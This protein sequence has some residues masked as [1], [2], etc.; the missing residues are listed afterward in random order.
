MS[1]PALFELPEGAQL[2]PVEP[3]S[4]TRGERRS[5]LVAA[6][7][8]SGMHPLG[9]VRLHAGASR[10]REGGGLRCGTCRY[11]Q[12]IAGHSDRSYAKCMFG[13]GIRDSHCESSD[14][15]AR[16]PSCVDYQPRK[17]KEGE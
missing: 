10:D 6:R 5:R 16:W 14:I 9:Y 13:D 7:I 3:E 17:P 15:R 11:R 8:A 4:L 2:P 1:E 12:N